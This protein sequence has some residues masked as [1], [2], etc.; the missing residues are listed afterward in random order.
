MTTLLTL[1]NGALLEIG[2]Q[3][4]ASTS[5]TTPV[6]YYLD[7]A[8]DAVVAEC[9]EAG[10][11]NHSLRAVSMAKDTTVV[12]VFG[13][14]NAFALPTDWVR[15]ARMSASD[16]F[17]PELNDYFLERRNLLANVDPLYMQYVSNSTD[18]GM[19]LTIWPRSFARYVEVALAERIVIR[20][21]QNKGEKERLERLTLPAAKRAALNKDALQEPQTR[22]M[23]MGSW[24]RARTGGRSSVNGTDRGL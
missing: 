11:W 12:P 4:L 9:L 21:T 10:S 2:P 19:N 3:R 13:W 24:N 17:E 5:D 6:R 8:Y 23:R 7:S 16:T 14:A 22:F 1:Y 18:Y 15:V 20:A